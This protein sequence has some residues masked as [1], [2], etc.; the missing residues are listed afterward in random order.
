MQVPADRILA[1]TDSPYLAPQPVRGRENEPAYV[2]HTVAALAQARGEDPDDL[3]ARIDANAT[4]A[5]GL[6]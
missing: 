5:F 6:P 1:E 4:A 3:G 2:V